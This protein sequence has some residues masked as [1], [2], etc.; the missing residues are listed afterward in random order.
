M[1]EDSEDK[2]QAATD[3]RRLQARE[4]GQAPLSREVVTASG[5]GAATLV[6]A[7]AAPGLGQALGLRLQAMLANSTATPGDALRQVATTALMALAPFAAA[8]ALAGGFAVLLQTGWLV[9]GK[10]MM[11]DLAR[12]DPR[13]GIKRIFGPGN[14]AEAGKALAKVLILAWAVWRAG[15]QALPAAT[16][17]LSWTTPTLLDRLARETVHLFVLVLACQCGIALLDAGWVRFRFARQLRMSP[18]EVKQEHKETEGDPHLKARIKQLRTTRAR[19][20]MLAAVQKAT[21]VITNPTHYAVAL[22]YERGAHAAPR[23][24]AKGVD[25]V[26]AKIREAAS[27][28]GVPLVANPPLARALHQLPLDAE[29]PPEHFK[30][31]AEIIAYV[32]RLRSAPRAGVP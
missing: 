8:V 18:E 13:R 21:V 31:V 32:W 30:A 24:V 17:S 7:M 1:A 5:I 16:A 10:A 22:A 29:V 6:L 27:E 4:E 19:R 20:R 12:L 26:A 28:H 23:V 15:N 3:R 25:E 14:A 9:H 2:T 11:P